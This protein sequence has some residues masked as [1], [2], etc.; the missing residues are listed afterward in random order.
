MQNVQMLPELFFMHVC[1]LLHHVFLLFILTISPD[2]HVLHLT[3]TPLGQY[4]SFLVFS[5]V[6]F[7][8]A[9]HH[10]ELE[11]FALIALK[12][13]KL[14]RHFAF[15]S[16]SEAV[17][18]F[19]AGRG[20][21][22]D[23]ADELEYADATK[24]HG[25][26]MQ[27]DD[28]DDDES[29]SSVR[30]VIISF[31]EGKG[32]E[33]T[34]RPR[35]TSPPGDQNGGQFDTVLRSNERDEHA[36]ASHI[37]VNESG[38]DAANQGINNSSSPPRT[39]LASIKEDVE[40]PS[41]EPT[42]RTIFGVVSGPGSIAETGNHELTSDNL[43]LTSAIALP[44]T[45]RHLVANDVFTT[46]SSGSASSA[47][48][49]SVSSDETALLE[50]VVLPLP[51]KPST[52]DLK[53]LTRAY[54]KDLKTSRRANDNYV[55]LRVCGDQAGYVEGQ[56]CILVEDEEGTVIKWTL[57]VA[58]VGADLKHGNPHFRL[59]KQQIVVLKEPVVALI[60]SSNELKYDIALRCDHL[61]DV[62][63]IC[64][65]NKEL[66]TVWTGPAN[67]PVRSPKFWYEKGSK[68]MS[69]KLA[70]ALYW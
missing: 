41:S 46:A 50:V 33:I 64:S 21:T 9:T 25:I 31:V 27:D 40:D 45:I 34:F 49:K 29:D 69:S 57:G 2:L 51:Y 42:H 55:V 13:H 67:K 32:D 20:P 12:K 23:A 53:Q 1:I 68:L 24:E 4:I 16:K 65:S 61:Q 10:E 5:M 56:K 8:M 17:E 35:A 3:I 11:E 43:S 59:I 70:D 48:L 37:H 15:T 26:V 36:S 30:E 62:H 18:Q 47:T 7:N 66:S 44:P 58:F 39:R 14:V 52:K 28:D 60:P 19:L 63:L 6:I 54:I 22:T 38:I